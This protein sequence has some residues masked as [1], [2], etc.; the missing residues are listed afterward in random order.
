MNNTIYSFLGCSRLNEIVDENATK[1]VRW[2]HRKNFISPN[3]H[4][5]AKV[6]IIWLMTSTVLGVIVT[7]S[8]LSPK[9]TYCLTGMSFIPFAK[10][11]YN[12]LKIHLL[13]C[14]D[15]LSLNS[16]IRCLVYTTGLIAFQGVFSHF[17]SKRHP[18]STLISTN[19][20]CSNLTLFGF[21][22]LTKVE[23]TY[24]KNL[25][26]HKQYLSSLQNKEIAIMTIPNNS[27]YQQTSI[28][29]DSAVNTDEED[30]ENSNSRKR[31]CTSFSN[32]IL[33]S[34]H[35]VSRYFSSNEDLANFQNKIIQKSKRLEKVNRDLQ[36]KLNQID[37][38]VIKRRDL[39]EICK[40][41]AE[42]YPEYILS[43]LD[44]SKCPSTG[45]GVIGGLGKLRLENIKLE[46]ALIER[47]RFIL[48]HQEVY[49]LFV[50]YCKEE[51]DH[52]SAEQK[53]PSE[54]QEIQKLLNPSDE[55]VREKK[56]L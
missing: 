19:L 45:D 20:A 38:F 37:A 41:Y 12:N 35:G 54:G 8:R 4:T 23:L 30:S 22:I 7:N 6:W 55:K 27:S 51:M 52:K 18:P 42:T 40:Q 36:E 50:K 29:Y 32:F 31:C 33:S 34:Y 1:V 24:A 25:N 16:K 39:Y 9:T 53:E 26:Q 13:T 17:L 48:R 56:C 5:Q 15:K 11:L 14:Y 49:D 28:T 21:L 3:N 10:P 46:S 2:M 47:E 43:P 44:L